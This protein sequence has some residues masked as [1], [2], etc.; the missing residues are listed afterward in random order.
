MNK[1]V[2]TGIIL[3]IIVLGLCYI[4]FNWNKEEV[5]DETSSYTIT[6][7][8]LKFK[9]EFEE[10]NDS[11]N[12]VNI[13]I[14]N[15]NTV[16]YSSYDE[17]FDKLE[18]EES[19]ILFFGNKSDENSRI[20]ASVLTDK[21]LILKEDIYYLD[22]KDDMDKK[23]LTSSGKIK[24]TKKGSDNYYSL[25]KKLNGYLPV[26]DGLNDDT[27]K[28]IYLPTVVFVSNGKVEKVVNIPKEIS[29]RKYSETLSSEELNILNNALS[30]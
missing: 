9:R 4:S 13:T 30:I 8:S 28:R 11:K 10:N 3:G 25:V 19:Y 29:N 17:I 18:T 27:I 22:I 23:E 5:K 7:D 21:A 20:M 1:N 24:V 2:I 14:K 6:N 16:I 26:Y 15:Y 12:K